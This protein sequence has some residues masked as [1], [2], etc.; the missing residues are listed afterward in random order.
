MQ[1][2]IVHRGKASQFYAA[3]SEIVVYFFSFHHRALKF[4][5]QTGQNTLGRM[6][7]CALL[8]QANSQYGQPITYLRLPTTSDRFLSIKMLAR[9]FRTLS[10]H[11]YTRVCGFSIVAAG[12]QIRNRKNKSLA[13]RRIFTPSTVDR[14]KGTLMK[15]VRQIIILLL[16]TVA[17]FVGGEEYVDVALDGSKI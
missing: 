7:S 3:E 8:D 5:T 12:R 17:H 9:V 10:S 16:C 13:G 15:R 2:K 4:Q 11:C 1:K 6:T 14:R